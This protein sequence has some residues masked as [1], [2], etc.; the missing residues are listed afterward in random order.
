[1]V[2]YKDVKVGDYVWLN[3][4][5]VSYHSNNNQ[6][7]I[8]GYEEYLERPCLITDKRSQNNIV[9]EFTVNDKFGIYTKDIKAIIN[10]EHFPE[11]FI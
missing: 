1:M 6:R 9:S 7:I 8:E 2:K 4:S 3:K 11:Y 5:A 10:P